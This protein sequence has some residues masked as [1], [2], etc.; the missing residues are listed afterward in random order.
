M[1]VFEGW[2]DRRSRGWLK[3]SFAVL[4]LDRGG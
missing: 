4:N 1:S 3:A 2:L